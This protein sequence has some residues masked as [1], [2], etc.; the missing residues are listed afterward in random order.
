MPQAEPGQAMTPAILPLLEAWLSRARMPEDA[1]TCAAIRA[2]WAQH[3]SM[4]MIVFAEPN[5]E[6]PK[7]A[8]HWLSRSSVRG[9]FHGVLMMHAQL[10]SLA[11][12]ILAQGVDTTRAAHSEILP[13]ILD[14]ITPKPQALNP[15]SKNPHP[16]ILN[17]QPWD[18]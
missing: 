12:S 3:P 16:Q 15:R 2:A 8:S 14:S 13:R 18:P 7:D 10:Q 17:A 9:I 1:R 4:A 5:R 6:H 11:S